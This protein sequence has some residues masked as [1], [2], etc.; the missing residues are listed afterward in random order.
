V[1]PFKFLHSPSSSGRHNLT[2]A[3]GLS[4][5]GHS[6]QVSPQSS[7]QSLDGTGSELTNHQ[8]GRLSDV[9]CEDKNEMR[10]N[11]ISSRRKFAMKEKKDRNSGS[12]VVSSHSSSTLTPPPVRNGREIC[13]RI[14]QKP[15]VTESKKSLTS[16]TSHPQVTSSSEDDEINVILR[17]LSLENYHPIFEEQ[18]IDMDAFLT[19]THGDLNELGITQELP[20]Q[21]I[22]HA[23]NQINVGKS[24]SKF[25]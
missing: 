6:G 21:Q 4:N 13:K 24:E 7:A 17:Q 14:I 15:E 20:R 19:L 3:G 2:T 22:L 8:P 1:R 23:I 18:E 25:T 12:S 16:T 5:T 9:V 10:K 11:E